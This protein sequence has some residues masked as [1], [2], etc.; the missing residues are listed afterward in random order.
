MLIISISAFIISIGIIFFFTFNPIKNFSKNKIIL[1]ED[2]INNLIILKQD[3]NLENNI[4]ND[5]FNLVKQNEKQYFNKLQLL[6][7]FYI[8]KVD[9]Y[10][11]QLNIK[12]DND[13]KI[14][15]DKII[16]KAIEEEFYKDIKVIFT[17]Y[18]SNENKLKLS[19]NEFFKNN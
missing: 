19:L 6:E 1:K 7:S 10:R 9:I 18:K 4:A 2:K 17:N 12:H 3:L 15:S 11:D 13:L 16:K 14:N 8:Q 5:K